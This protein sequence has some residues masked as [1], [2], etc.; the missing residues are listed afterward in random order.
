MGDKE[1]K[2]RIKYS[3]CA[4][5]RTHLQVG[6]EKAARILIAAGAREIH[7]THQGVRPL[8]LNSEP[9]SVGAHAELDI[10]LQGVRAAGMP[11]NSVSMGSA[12]QMG[13]VRMAASPA[14]GAAKPSGE[15]WEA[16]GLFVGDTSTFPT[17][18]GVNPMYTCASIAY[19]VAQQVKLHLQEP[20]HCEHREEQRLPRGLLHRLSQRHRKG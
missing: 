17:A 11:M 12:H 16:P 5:D 8:V 14:L 2:L 6:C 13:T 20:P 19:I 3:A 18:S 10:W 1:G 9:A 4:R 7:M 15:L